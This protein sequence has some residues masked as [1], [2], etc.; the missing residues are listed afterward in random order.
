V[1]AKNANLL[2][3]DTDALTQ[4]DIASEATWAANVPAGTRIKKH[5]KL[6]FS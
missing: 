3:L 4:H 1:R 5:K 2:A 6:V